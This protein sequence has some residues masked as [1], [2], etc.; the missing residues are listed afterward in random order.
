MCPLIVFRVYEKG[1]LTDEGE[2]SRHGAKKASLL[3]VASCPLTLVF[4]Q[5]RL[6]PSE[7]AEGSGCEAVTL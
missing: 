5:G 6:G 7:N 2:G 1:A 4:V 3:A